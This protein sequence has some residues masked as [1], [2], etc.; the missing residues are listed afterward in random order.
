M[1]TTPAAPHLLYVYLIR[2]QAMS[3]LVYSR[4]TGN[5]Q[6]LETR[7]GLYETGLCKPAWAG[8][9]VSPVDSNHVCYGCTV[10]RGSYAAFSGAFSSWSPYANGAFH[11]D[12]HSLAFSPNNGSEI[13][14]G[15]HGGVSKL[16]LGGSTSDWVSLYDG[17]GV[18]TIWSFDDWEGNDSLIALAQQDVGTNITIDN[19][20][21]WGQMAGEDGYGTR[22]DDQ[23]G[24]LFFRQNDGTSFHRLV[25]SPL[26][27]SPNNTPDGQWL[28]S[29]VP[30]TFPMLNHPK[31][32]SLYFGFTELYL[33]NA[34]TRIDSLV[35]IDTFPATNSLPNGLS[36]N[37]TNCDAIGASPGVNQIYQWVQP[38]GSGGLSAPG[39][40]VVRTYQ[41]I[42]DKWGLKSNLKRYQA[43]DDNR[44]ILEIGF[45]ED[46][47]SDYTYLVTLGDNSENR[48]SDFYFN[49]GLGCDTCFV[50]KNAGLPIDTTAAG[51]DPNPI[52]G[53]AVDPLD[54]KRLW[55]SFSGYSKDIKVYYSSDSGSTWTSYD[56]ANNALANLNVP[57]NNIVY[58]RGTKDRLYIAT[59]VG[60]YVREDGGDWLRY[61][62]N[63]PNVRTTELKINYCLG[64]LR[65]ATFGRGVWESD[66]LPAETDIS[67]RSFRT[68]SGTEIWSTDKNMS[69]DIKVKTGATLIL[70]SIT[71]NMPKGGLIVVETGGILMVNG[72]TI[73]NLCGQTWQ[74]IQVW[75]NSAMPQLPSHQGMIGL[76][77]S[78]IEYAKNAISPWQ[79]GHYP[80][81]IAGTGGTGGLIRAMDSEF[82]NNW[83]SIDFMQYRSTTAEQSSLLNCTFTVNDAYRPFN[84]DSIPFFLGHISMW[85]IGGTE[86]KGCS[87]K[88]ER[89]NKVGD[90]ARGGSFGL[91]SLGGSPQLRKWV[92]LDKRNRFE[93]LERGLDL[94]G[95]SLSP[96]TATVDECNFIDN[97][98]ALTIRAQNHA[99]IIRDSFVIGGF[100]AAAPNHYVVEEYGLGLIA[101]TAFVVEQNV[102]Q[103]SSTDQTLGSWV[104]DAGA[105]GNQIRNNQYHNLTGGNLA[106]GRND[107][108]L[109]DDG[110]QYLCNQNSSNAY[111]FTVLPN[112][113]TNA[114]PASIGAQQGSITQASRNTLS[115]PIQ[116]LPAQAQFY[117]YSYNPIL[118]QLNA[119]IAYYYTSDPQVSSAESPDPALLFNTNHQVVPF[120]NTAFCA[121][122]YT[123]V[124]VYKISDAEGSPLSLATLKA[125]YYQTQ[126]AYDLLEENYSNLDPAD[127]SLVLEQAGELAG[128]NRE[129]FFWANE[130]IRAYSNDSLPH[131]DSIAVWIQKKTGSEAVY[132]LVE[133]YW[134]IGQYNTALEWIDSI[135]AQYSLEERALNNQDD[136]K[137]L[138]QLLYTAYQAG[139]TEANLEKAEV[140]VLEEIAA[141]K[142]GF[143]AVQAGNILNFFY[144]KGILYYPT[145]PDRTPIEGRYI[146]ATNSKP[147]FASEEAILEGSPSPAINWV[148]IS[149]QLPKGIKKGDLIV[150]ATSG[151]KIAQFKLQNNLGQLTLNTKNWAAGI[152]FAVLYSEGQACKVFKIV[153]Q[154]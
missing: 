80:D 28:P 69:R 78:R 130:V 94:T 9:S 143:A 1:A 73:T 39:F 144:R 133:H 3:L 60:V 104:E 141:T 122:H 7:T 45:S 27:Y 44:R 135:P 113:M 151:A 86:I 15:T 48:R 32:D 62:E 58:Q 90:A 147:S 103:A 97:E 108:V 72:S 35:A 14:A 119:P 74:G 126:T 82:V 125:N 21:S 68:I 128:A 56:D 146:P 99:V 38:V 124:G 50:L 142:W 25:M 79:V 132:E 85:G 2:H 93:G 36:S 53:I 105:G 16:P 46:E 52:T 5:W 88:D 23:S 71:L 11:A 109:P 107:G 31:N 96:L 30:S 22:I 102:F 61:G 131:E 4:N 19:G 134:R 24:D 59:D 37:A 112:I 106:H 87:F 29:D 114:A 47:N 116:S 26:S 118:G 149:Y 18:A 138:K 55:L 136:Y 12:V 95:P 92:Y 152:Y 139:R 148:D 145:L 117:N 91:L 101:N 67:Y 34:H 33:R 81:I 51:S 70:D 84:Q 64:K 89:S 120:G 6:H 65:A 76:N 100:A 43:A 8:I 150:T 41:T 42:L 127:S 123:G 63:F 49:N 110:M 40:C 77:G 98:Q 115:T 121:D 153:L 66:L 10:V 57:I 137:R 129:V 75:G 140:E 111:D 20:T 13:F 54:G 83:R 154:K 17:L